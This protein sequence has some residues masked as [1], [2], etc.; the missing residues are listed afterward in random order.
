M[1]R[2]HLNAAA[3][4]AIPSRAIDRAL[5]A[6]LGREGVASAEISVTFAGDDVIA[7]LHR[8]HLGH[9]GP[10]DVIAFALHGPGEDPLGD[11]YIGHQQAL[12]QAAALRIPEEEELVRLAI[13][14]ALHVLGHTHPEG[15]GRE[16]SAMYRI[17]ED[18]LAAAFGSREPSGPT[19]MSGRP[20]ETPGP[21]AALGPQ[22]ATGP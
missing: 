11:I 1:I 15:P 9:A 6:L 10:T 7:A 22:A 8:R 18:V 20:R 14:G 19:G 4:R 5:H 17:Q 16:S 13:H 3:A 12:R 2:L 21:Q